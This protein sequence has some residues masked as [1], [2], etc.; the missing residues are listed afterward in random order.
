MM[1]IVTVTQSH[2]LVGTDDLLSI[3]VYQRIVFCWLSVGLPPSG[4]EHS[5]DISYI[6]TPGVSTA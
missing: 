6:I 1:G 3:G 2:V 5:A 4:C